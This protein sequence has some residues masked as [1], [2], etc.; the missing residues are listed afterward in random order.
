MG[1]PYC[2]VAGVAWGAQFPIAGRALKLIDPFSFTLLRYLAVSLILVALLLIAE[3]TKAL[4][5]EGKA[6]KVWFFGTMAFTV[7]NFLVFLGQKTA[8]PSGA[9]L[10]SIMMALMPM[11]SVLVTWVY[12]RAAPGKFT[13]TCI[14]IAFLGVSMVITKGDVSVL[15]STS[16]DLIPALLILAGVF[17]WV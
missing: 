15:S 3:G 16:G 2:L 9:V 1:A 5:F 10:A 11:M 17:G 12:K 13:L 4:S 6:L 8:G 14:L 7:Y